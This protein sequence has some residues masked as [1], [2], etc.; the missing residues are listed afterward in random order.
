M[1]IENKVEDEIDHPDYFEKDNKMSNNLNKVIAN[2][3][4]YLEVE[5]MKPSLIGYSFSTDIFALVL[6]ALLIT[7]SIHYSRSYGC[8]NTLEREKVYIL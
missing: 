3:C 8:F 5:K 6:M 1:K 7:S 4:T 2:Y